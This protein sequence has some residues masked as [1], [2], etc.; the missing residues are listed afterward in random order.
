MKFVHKIAIKVWNS[1]DIPESWALAY[2]TLLAKTD[3]L[4]NCAEFRPIAITNTV[5]KIIFSV[6]SDNLRSL[7]SRIPSLIVKLKMVF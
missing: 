4:S 6:V 5:G 1:E 2:I 3:D 7:W